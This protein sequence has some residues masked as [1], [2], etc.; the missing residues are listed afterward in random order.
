MNQIY[1][2]QRH[3]SLKNVQHSKDNIYEIMKKKI[4][5]LINQFRK[6]PYNSGLSIYNINDLEEYSKQ[7]QTKQTLDSIQ[8]ISLEN[9]IWLGIRG[10]GNCFYRSIIILYLLELFKQNDFTECDNFIKRVKSMKNISINSIR[11]EPET[12]ALQYILICFL[13]QIKNMKQLKNMD[14]EDIIEQYN[15]RPEVDLAA[16][17]ICRNLIFKTFQICKNN[18]SF[19]LFIEDQMK[20][21][22][23]EML[24]KYGEY[25]EDIIIPLASQAFRCNLLVQNFY[26]QSPTSINTEKLLYQPF[27]QTIPIFTTLS[28]LFTKGHYES[29][30]STTQANSFEQFYKI[31]KQKLS[32]QQS[33]NFEFYSEILDQL[34]IDEFQLQMQVEIKSQESIQNNRNDKN[35]IDPQQKQ[36]Q[37]NNF[38]QTD[39]DQNLNK[40]SKE[41]S[42][43]QKKSNEQLKQQENSNEIIQ[44]QQSQR[45]L[46]SNQEHQKKLYEQYLAQKKGQLEQSI[47]MK[48]INEKQNLLNEQNIK[49]TNNISTEESIQVNRQTSKTYLSNQGQPKQMNQNLIG[50]RSQK[51]LEQNIQLTFKQEQQ[52]KTKESIND[53]QQQIIHEERQEQEMQSFNSK[54]Y[55][56]EQ[57]KQLQNTFNLNTKID[58]KH[59]FSK[60][61]MNEQQKNIK[62]EENIRYQLQN[63]NYLTKE[64]LKQSQVKNQNFAEKEFQ[65]NCQPKSKIDEKLNH[66][67]EQKNDQQEKII[68]EESQGIQI[69]NQNILIKEPLNQNQAYNQ[70]FF[71]KEHQKSIMPNTQIDE[72]QSLKEQRNSQQNQI[73]NEEKIR[74]QTQNI[75]SKI[76]T[77]QEFKQDEISNQNIEEKPIQK[78]DKNQIIQE[79]NIKNNS[80][81][82]TQQNKEIQQKDKNIQH[83]KQTPKTIK[84]ANFQ[85]CKKMIPLNDL[86]ISKKGPQQ[87]PVFLCKQCQTDLKNDTIHKNIK[88]QKDENLENEYTN[89]L[90]IQQKDEQKKQ[91]IQNKQAENKNNKIELETKNKKSD[92]ANQNK[93]KLTTVQK[94]GTKMEKSQ[95]FQCQLNVEKLGKFKKFI[96]CSEKQNKWICVNCAKKLIEQG[97]I[98][99]DCIIIEGIKYQISNS[100]Q[101]Y[102]TQNY[103]SHL[104]DQEQILINKDILI[105]Q[106]PQQI[107]Q[108]NKINK[109]QNCEECKL[110]DKTFMLKFNIKFILLNDQCQKQQDCIVCQNCLIL[111]MTKLKE[112]EY[113]IESDNDKN[114]LYFVNKQV[115][116]QIKS[117]Q[118]QYFNLLFKEEKVKQITKIREETYKNSEEE[119]KINLSNQCQKQQIDQ[120]GEQREQRNYAQYQQRDKDIA[121]IQSNQNNE[122]ISNQKINEFSKHLQNNQ[123]QNLNHINISSDEFDINEKLEEKQIEDLSKCESCQI[124]LENDPYKFQ[125]IVKKG[126]KDVSAMLCCSCF[127]QIVIQYKTL[128]KNRI[129]I[130]NQKQFII[131]NDCYKQQQMLIQIFLENKEEEKNQEFEQQQIQLQQQKLQQKQNEI[132]S[133]KLSL[134]DEQNQNEQTKNIQN[135]CEN[136]RHSVEQDI[137]KYELQV[138]NNKQIFNTALCL[139]CFYELFNENGMILNDTFVTFNQKQY[140]IESNNYRSKYK[141][142]NSYINEFYYENDNK[143]EISKKHQIELKQFQNKDKQ[144]FYLKNQH[145][146]QQQQ[147][148]LQQKQTEIQYKKSSLSDEQNQ[149]EKTK[150]IQKKC[151][152]CHNPVEQDIYKYQIQI[153]NNKQTFN[154]VLCLF[155]FYELYNENRTLYKDTFVTFNQKQYFIKFDNYSQYCEIAKSHI[156]QLSFEDNNKEITKINQMEFKQFQI[157]DKQPSY[158]KNQ[159]NSYL[160]I[161]YLNI[162]SQQIQDKQSPKNTNDLTRFSNSKYP[163]QQRINSPKQPIKAYNYQFEMSNIPN[164]NEELESRK[165]KM[166]KDYSL[167]Q[168]TANQQKILPAQQSY[169]RNSSYDSRSRANQYYSQQST[170]LLYQDHFQSSNDKYY[171]QNTIFQTRPQSSEKVYKNNLIVS[172][173][174]YYTLDK[175]SFNNYYPYKK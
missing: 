31:K 77:I 111:L 67:N 51:N 149:N 52:N 150:S 16:I 61:Q 6:N 18:P 34:N 142:F 82:I 30:I 106:I 123:K 147:Q 175:K 44:K 117:F 131:D 138:M 43:K 15:S 68:I 137:C 14:M 19:S 113:C 174:H 42:L 130:L 126:G 50:S 2:F 59:S 99:Q 7:Y 71:E 54:I 46:Q 136:C 140:F 139:F 5:D 74:E 1:S 11:E 159:K 12:Q 114:K 158:L 125:T 41:V 151:E 122:L 124:Q 156:Y 116:E 112:G 172:P 86:Q 155:C 94:N 166:M 62:N 168:Y 76:Q 92:L 23:P 72:K 96:L 165:N 85:Q 102:I 64:S 146:Q 103:T 39:E 73:I 89:K 162:K 145:T 21:K 20:S 17:V 88:N 60:E 79:K 57:I 105:N 38:I 101:I 118:Q 128:P 81:A 143:S 63:S 132:E 154:T 157:K 47:K 161:S 58:E 109:N 28:V 70:N 65:K 107:T 141:K 87:K 49:E 32:Y 121:S 9:K 127:Q 27:N 66:S 115:K 153:I 55:T 164:K 25:A 100:F 90:L 33:H 163:N 169:Q 170:D 26:R 37:I 93:Q 36:I 173:R 8:K 83:N 171:S 84:C 80:N 45:E 10:D 3:S 48:E 13:Y 144:Q 129:V 4:K 95:C 35:D 53:Q 91:E 24:L 160:P 167:D 69:L 134:S 133:K 40:S 119:E 135:K 97:I 152:N 22:I 75:S 148:Q 108:Q 120:I 56:Q 110:D 104:K 29:L 78:I 98:T